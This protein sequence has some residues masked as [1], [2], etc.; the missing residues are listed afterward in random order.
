MRSSVRLIA[1]AVVPLLLLAA[2]SSTDI[3]EP[4]DRALQSA[5]QMTSRG[6]LESSAFFAIFPDG[7]PRQYVSFLFSDAGAAERPPV[8]G[9]GEMSPDEE[10]SMRS[11]GQPVWPANVGMTHSKANPTLGM[12]V[13]WKW[14]DARRMIILEGYVDPKQP[15]AVVR[16]TP[17]PSGVRP[18]DLARMSAQSL[19]EQGGRAQGF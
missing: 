13:V 6:W 4:L 5:E 16:E 19:L 11:I 9:G 14:D 1:A 8:E 17:F 15:P 2:C 10:T 18:S 7:T 12:Q 3:P